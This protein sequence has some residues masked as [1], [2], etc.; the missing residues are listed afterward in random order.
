MNPREIGLRSTIDNII[1]SNKK[2]KNIML[3]KE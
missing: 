1:G 3:R 2:H